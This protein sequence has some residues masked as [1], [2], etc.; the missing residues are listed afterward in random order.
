METRKMFSAVAFG[1]L[2]ILVI[3]LTCSLIFSLLLRFT[4]MQESSLQWL[5]MA[6]SFFAL[7]AGGFIS[8][9]RGKEKGWLMGGTT[10]LLFTGI[11]ILYQF[12]G[13]ETGFSMEQ[14]FYH[15]GYLA[16]AVFGGIIGVNLSSSSTNV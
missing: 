2:T 16:T 15:L 6:L 5:I 1:L 7:F 9:G 10:A 8:G 13:Q 12:L 11:V 3:I 4:N 14:T